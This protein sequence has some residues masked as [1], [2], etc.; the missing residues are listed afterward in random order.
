MN[1]GIGNFFIHNI[2]A[3]LEK[4]EFHQLSCSSDMSPTER[5]ARSSCLSSYLPHTS[6]FV[7]FQAIAR[8]IFG[9]IHQLERNLHAQQPGLNT[10]VV[11]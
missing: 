9:S 10:E 6:H 1:D 4:W 11:D 8:P 2:S 3:I 5:L 7:Q